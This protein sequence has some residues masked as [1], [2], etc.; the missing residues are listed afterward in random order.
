MSDLVTHGLRYL[1]EKLKYDREHDLDGNFDLPLLRW[2]CVQLA[3]AMA[4][5]GFRDEPVDLWLKLAEEDPLPEV[6]YAVTPST[7][8]DA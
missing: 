6:R 4:Q 2:L 8:L 1:A 5:S 3:Q 7:S